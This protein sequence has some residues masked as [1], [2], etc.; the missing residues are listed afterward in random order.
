ML[1]AA[2]GRLFR[3]PAAGGPPVE[4]RLS[5]LNGQ[6][7]R[8]ILLPDGRHF[9]FTVWRRVRGDVFL[10]STD[11]DRM[12]KLVE[13][14]SP[15]GFAVP[16]HLLFVRGATL[17][18]QRLDVSRESM[19][20]EP[21]LVASGISPGQLF[22]QVQMSVS[23]SDNDVLAFQAPRG[24]SVG[25]LKWFD[26]TGRA[27]QSLPS[28]PDAEYLNP[29]VSPDGQTIAANRIDPQT[30][31]WDIWLFDITRGV[32]SKLT[33]DPA[34]DF[35]P[36]WS[37]DGK[38]IVFGSERGGRLGLYRQAVV[39]GSPAERLIDLDDSV[40]VVPTDWS[41]S[42]YILYQRQSGRTW[43]IWALPLE[44]DRKPILL[45]DETYAPYGPHLSP[46][47]TWLAYNS[48]ETGPAEIFVRRFLADGPKKQISSGGG[49]HPRWTRDGKELVYWS[50]PGGIYAHDFSATSSEIRV[51]PRRT[52]L[53]RPPLSLIDGR[54]HYDITRDGS[55]LIVR[56]P[57]G[58]QGPGI[59]VILNWT[60]KL[61]K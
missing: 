16:D 61:K 2:E 11:S 39:G 3:L 50:P 59:K 18:T 31:R 7:R 29:A 34:D 41:R 19:I 56:Q 48:F 13:T 24:G 22:G 51:G 54:T 4:L 38:D 23:A 37:P 30:G 12:T 60:S 44:G 32:P 5:G 17:M 10:A 55:R 36:V 49:V 47:G 9:V 15:A 57:A 43:S 45:Q 25:E 53:D 21:E 40:A 6:A 28:P 52:L 33:T 1:A 20:G 42:G 8:P 14:D 27:E 35:D 26:R 46:D 58:P